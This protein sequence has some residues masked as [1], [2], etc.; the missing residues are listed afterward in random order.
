[1]LRFR[2]RFR[3]QGLGFRL[4]KVTPKCCPD[5]RWVKGG[6]AEVLVHLDSIPR[7]GIS[8]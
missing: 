2:V 5:I 1:M 7:V 4:H 6:A 3:F 8:R